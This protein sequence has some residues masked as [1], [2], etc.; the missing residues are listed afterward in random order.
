MKQFDT[1]IQMKRDSA[2]NWTSSNPVLLNGEIIIV[3]TNSGDI[4]YKVGDGIKT[5][6]QLP[7]SDESLIASMLSLNG[8]TMNGNINMSNHKITGLGAPVNPSDAVRQQ[9]LEV[10][11]NEIDD[12]I[13][14]T[15]AITLPIADETKL[16]GVKIGEGINVDGEGVISAESQFPTG[17]TPG[18]LLTKTE[19]GE[20]W[21]DAP[22]GL[23][24]GGAEGQVLAKTTTG[25]GWITPAG[26][27][28]N[29]VTGA[30]VF[31]DFHNTA[32]G[33]FSHAEG[34]FTSATG[35]LSHAEGY[36]SSAIGDYS[37]AEGD[38]TEAKNGTSHAEGIKTIANGNGQHAQGKY[39]IEDTIRE[40]AHIVGNGTNF[41]ARSNAHTLDWDGNA[42]FAGDVFVGGT[43]QSSGEKL[44]KEPTGTQGQFLGF[45][46][47]NVVGAVDGPEGLPSGGTEGQILYQ[48]A[49]GAEWGDKPVMYVNITAESGGTYSADKTAQE[50]YEAYQSGYAVFAVPFDTDI[51]I[52]LLNYAIKGNTTNEYVAAFSSV[53]METTYS[54]LI[55]DISNY[56][57]FAKA[58]LDASDITFTP[59]SPLTSDNVQDAIGEVYTKTAP[60]HQTITLSSSAW[61]SNSQTVTVSGVTADELDQLIT[62][63]PAIASQS[64]YYEAGIMCTNQGT[65]S[66]TFTC[67]TV[68][69]S[70]L[71]VYVVIQP[72]G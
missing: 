62:P 28:V 4:R 51:P 65:N 40:Y 35:A 54:F 16:G 66:L 63:T 1:R 2:T 12:I 64:A 41:N 29:N 33:I 5:Y 48:G 60:T 21:S 17:G 47:D 10:L 19:T 32:T 38:G 68:P 39:N 58:K 53:A 45:T 69:T 6:T 7:F 27:A 3:D 18:Q 9:D 52:M 44:M 59:A 57:A 61:S 30:E 20:E 67:Q 25:N 55:N 26:Q 56:F 37:H 34:R 70:N 24:E 8:G 11:S 31:N 49:N 42:W 23:P 14:G 13:E 36:Y 22:S 50:I 15:T 72:L 43:S 71:T 46:A